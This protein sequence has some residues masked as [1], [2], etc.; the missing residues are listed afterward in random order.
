MI[1]VTTCSADLNAAANND[2]KTIAENLPH[3]DWQRQSSPA[4]SRT[5]TGFAGHA[6]MVLW[7]P[8]RQH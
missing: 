8:G 5:G 4:D 6:T 2:R 1:P 7:R 3:L